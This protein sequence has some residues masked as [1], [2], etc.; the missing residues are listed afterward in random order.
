MDVFAQT[1]L[2]FLI[3]IAFAMIAVAF[4]AMLV[5]IVLSLWWFVM[6]M[7]EGLSKDTGWP[8]ASFLVALSVPFL[9]AWASYTVGAYVM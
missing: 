8:I 5:Y 2:G 9:V 3:I 1:A 6:G 7:A 4:A